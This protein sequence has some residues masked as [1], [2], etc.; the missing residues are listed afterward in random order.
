MNVFQRLMIYFLKTIINS[1]RSNFSGTA[2]RFVFAAFICIWLS[3]SGVRAA[4]GD[5]DPAFG[6][7]GFVTTSLGSG[8]ERANAAARQADG[9]IVFAG[10]RGFASFGLVRYNADGTLDASFDTDGIVTTAIGTSS[11]AFGVAVQADGKIVVTGTTGI[12]GGPYFL[13]RYN[14]N[15]AL[16]AT[17]GSGGIFVDNT[18]GAPQ[19]LVIQPDGKILTAGSRVNS[20]FSSSEI[21][22]ARHNADGSF[23]SSFDG[24][25]KVYTQAADY[26]LGGENFAHA[27][28]LQPDGK[29]VVAGEGSFVNTARDFSLI[30]YNPDGSLDASFDGDGKVRTAFGGNGLNETARA[31][32][33]Q[34][35]GRIVA[36]G[37]AAEGAVSGFALARYN[38]DGS[39]DASFGGD[40]KV[41]TSNAGGNE[42]INSV[43]VQ[44]DGRIVAAGIIG[45][46]IGVVRYNPD[47]SPDASFGTGG[48]A[49]TTVYER[50]YAAGRALLLEP[51]GRIVV[52][53]NARVGDNTDE[54]FVFARYNKDGTPA[55]EL[56]V[57]GRVV[58][59]LFGMPSEAHD[60]VV[61]PDGKI[62]AAG[63]RTVNAAESLGIIIRYTADGRIDTSFAGSTSASG[64]AGVL[65]PG[66]KEHELNHIILQPDGKILA[67]GTYEG[68]YDAGL[69]VVRFNP[70]GERDYTFGGNNN[71]FAIVSATDGGGLGRD[72]ALQ[73]D[74]KIVVAG[75]SI[76]ADQTADYAVYRFTAD[77]R[78]D[79]TFGAG[80]VSVLSLSAGNDVPF[81]A[82]VQP[83][84][85]IILAG[86]R[87]FSENTGS[88]DV[89]LVR[90]NQNGGVDASFGTGGTVI[91]KF[92]SY[93]N[94]AAEIQLQ[95]DGKLVAAGVVCGDAACAGGE[96]VILRYTATGAL[97]ASFDGD[98]SVFVK[99]PGSTSVA[100]AS[101]AIQPDG[102]IVVA[103][104]SVSPAT[105]SDAFAARYNEDG[106]PDATFGA[107]GIVTADV[108]NSQQTAS[109]VALQRDG[110][111]VIA[112]SSLTGTRADFAVWRFLGD[113]RATARSTKFDYDGDGRADISLFRPSDRVWYIQNSG[114]GVSFTQFGLATDKIVPADYDGDGKTDI[115]VF[116]PETGVWFITKSTGGFQFV[117]FGT[118]EDLP[119]PGDFN[120]DGKAEVAVF[121]PSTGVWFILNTE[122]FVSTATQFGASEDKPV[123]ADYDG[124]GK[125]EIAVYRPSLGVWFLLNQTT[126][127]TN[128]TRFGI[129]TDK[130]VQADYD[131]DGKTDI[132]VYRPNEGN[133]YI[134]PTT[135]GFTVTKF[136]LSTDQ[137]TPADYDGDGRTDF[138]VYRASEGNWYQLKSRD[139]FSITKFGLEID[140]PTPN[141]FVY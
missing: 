24:D 52:A 48:K 77:G 54:D 28:A 137:P 127:Q 47:G 88:G 46:Q 13:A 126:G 67:V 82:V 7:V 35:D 61:Q 21:V 14:P 103:G 4:P 101:L 115:A 32:F 23:D 140:K 141:A 59:N 25:G 42:I 8:I 84:G 55:A 11:E 109:A 117:Q 83:D 123:A 65:I 6:A 132:A 125:A 18:L 89:A 138:A 50:G 33:V 86:A 90:F 10:S 87:N 44:P 113:A 15:G 130:P 49:L 107:N 78:R 31:I 134:L 136:G 135:G 120:G 70:N 121:R 51:D 43:A 62:I 111:I 99:I 58:T 1:C 131:G 100:A 110:K 66:A 119:Q 92:G 37:G 79:T 39:L 96:G 102:K 69:Y 27:L 80:G 12:S 5:P 85:K 95:A 129:A 30:R 93:A 3:V 36:A 116:R 53:G 60:V 118:S 98:G 75:A 29:I 34:A 76:N 45:L 124:D 20:N 57:A 63:V 108:N 81:S 97:D 74:G 91:N 9:K 73:P 112:G 17:F 68:E 41:V 71:G 133:W 105:Q 114:G 128:A 22:V 94:I 104:E 16:D 72:V 64:V 26:S 139:G 106:T 2:S 19:A 122:T 40:G 38:P 56:G